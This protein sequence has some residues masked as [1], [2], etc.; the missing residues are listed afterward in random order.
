V[1]KTFEMPKAD[2]IKSYENYISTIKNFSYNDLTNL[3][4]CL[5]LLEAYHKSVDTNVGYRNFII[6]VSRN[7]RR[8]RLC[9][10]FKFQN[11]T[12]PIRQIYLY[13]THGLLRLIIA[14]SIL[15]TIKTGV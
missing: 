6:N 11:A 2:T 3:N 10:S 5:L 1:E 7:F 13:L 14:E 12:L 15:G 4:K 8:N 9:L